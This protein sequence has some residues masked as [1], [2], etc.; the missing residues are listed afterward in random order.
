MVGRLV[1][2]QLEKPG[3]AAPNPR[4]CSLRSCQ[5]W[6]LLV[7]RQPGEVHDGG[8][9]GLRVPPHELGMAEFPSLF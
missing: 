7:A 8:E 3:L 9:R 6:C 1:Y 2:Q 5:P 4:R